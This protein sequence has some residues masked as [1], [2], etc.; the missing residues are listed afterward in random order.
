MT[1]TR[2][3][4]RAKPEPEPRVHILEDGTLEAVAKYINDGKGKKGGWGGGERL[5]CRAWIV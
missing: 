1:S 4:T 5:H 3:T 2:A